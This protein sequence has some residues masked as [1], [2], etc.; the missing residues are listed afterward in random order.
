MG[1]KYRTTK[2]TTIK[3][4]KTGVTVNNESTTTEPR[5]LNGQQPKPPRSL[6]AFY[7]HQIFTLDST[8]VE[9]QI[10]SARIEAF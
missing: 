2:H 1:I 3:T 6:N 8:V 9:V 5:P 4:P 10:C 7:W